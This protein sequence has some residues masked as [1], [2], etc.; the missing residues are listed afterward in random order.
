MTDDPSLLPDL[1]PVPVPDRFEGLG[2]D[3]A[4]TLRQADTIAAGFNPGTRERLHRDAA[5][6]RT[7]SGL[8]CRD[9]RHLYRT[10]AGNSDFLKCEEAGVRNGRGSWGPDM[11]GW[12]PA[13]R[14]F[15]PKSGDM[16]KDA[17]R[18]AGHV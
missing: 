8:R 13:C 2:R 16:R 15:E 9:C 5:K 11:R 12:W 18:T 17:N 4:R 10:G 1:E 14:L 3:A 6:D 7:G